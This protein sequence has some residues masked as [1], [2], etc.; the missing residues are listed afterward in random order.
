MFGSLP[1]HRI[2]EQNF[3]D[4]RGEFYLTRSHF[5]YEDH[6]T[7]LNIGMAWQL[8]YKHEGSTKIVSANSDDTILAVKTQIM[9]KSGIPTESQI[10]MFG[11]KTLLDDLMLYDYGIHNESTLT[12][13]VSSK[14]SFSVPKISFSVN[15]YHITDS[16]IVVSTTNVRDV[17]REC[18]MGEL[19]QLLREQSGAMI[20]AESQVL[21]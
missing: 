21:F 10:L 16:K 8:F 5:I 14:M 2:F 17:P 9:N 3:L 6:N 20:A 4:L 11:A 13:R 19:K 12:L 1:E 15:W 18:T 7:E